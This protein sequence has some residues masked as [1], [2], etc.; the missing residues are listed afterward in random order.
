VRNRHALFVLDRALLNKTTTMPEEMR[1]SLCT[2][3][4]NLPETTEALNDP[5]NTG[6]SEHLRK[7][8]ETM[9]EE[10]PGLRCMILEVCF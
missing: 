4:C 3:L 8:L 6:H 1:S 5:V 7:I 9:A 2:L 10:V